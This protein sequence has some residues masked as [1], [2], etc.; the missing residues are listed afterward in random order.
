MDT[1]PHRHHYSATV[2]SA[3]SF[4]EPVA[5]HPSPTKMQTRASPLPIA[6]FFIYC[7]SQAPSTQLAPIPLTC[8]AAEIVRD[9]RAGTHQGVSTETLPGILASSNAVASSDIV[10]DAAAGG[11]VMVA[12]IRERDAGEATGRSLVL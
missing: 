3:I 12:E 4:A 7:Q 6:S 11:D 9:F 2:P 5:L 1:V 10:G 8:H